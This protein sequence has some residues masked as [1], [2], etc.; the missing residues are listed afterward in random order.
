MNTHDL[1]AFLAVVETGSI[2]AASARLH[3]TQPGLSR[4]IQ[5]LEDALGVSLF[6]RQ[7]KPLRPTAAGRDAYDYGRRVLRALDDL[8]T[9]VSTDG[10][11]GG[12]LRLGITPYLSELALAAP[13][14]S[15]RAA[16][17]ALAPTVSLGWPEQLLARV[18]HSEIDAAAF[19]LAEGAMPPGDLDATELGRE[20]VLFVAARGLAVP[21]PATL[22]ELSEFPW[23]LNQDGCGFRCLM[24]RAFDAAHLPFRIGIEAPGSALRLSL[25]A[26]GMGIALVTPTALADSPEREKLTVI[27]PADFQPSVRVWVVHRAPAG[28]L[29]RPLAHFKTALADVLSDTPPQA[30]H[31]ARAA[32]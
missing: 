24:R 32:A 10:T 16:F 15:L 22:R 6:E 25:A 3:I 18:R 11:L 30:L 23:I 19:C 5:S 2:V 4:R 27:E 9:A 7:S 12:E 20:P 13:L 29:A 21:S 14:D 1:E 26:R 28:R 17:P 31:A 8:K